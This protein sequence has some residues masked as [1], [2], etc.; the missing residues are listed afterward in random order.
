M[1]GWRP[2]GTA[3]RMKCILLWGATDVAEGEIKNWKMDTGYWSTGAE[4]WVWEGRQVR[5][6][7]PQPTHWMPLPE[8]PIIGTSA[9]REPAR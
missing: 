4:T 3:P 1:S 5:K 2:I 6:Y 8:P 7:D 9:E